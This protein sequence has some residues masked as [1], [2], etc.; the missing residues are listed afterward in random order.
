MLYERSAEFAGAPARW[1]PLLANTDSLNREA[2][3]PEVTYEFQ[4]R[5][6]GTV[7]TQ[8][9]AKKLGMTVRWREHPFEWIEPQGWSVQRDFAN[10]PFREFR[11]GARIEPA[12]AGVR[13][14]VFCDLTPRG[15]FGRLTAGAFAAKELTGLLEICRA[16]EGYLAGRS[17]SPYP[18]R[19]GTALVDEAALA[20]ALA[21][22]KR[23]PVPA[24]ICDRLARH[25]REAPEEF[26][27]RMR[28]FELA[29]AWRLDRRD[30]LRTMLYATRAGLLELAYAL[31]CTACRGAK[32]GIGTM[33]EIGREGHCQTC[34]VGFK[35]DFDRS[36]E[37]RFNVHPGVRR[38][39]P[40]LYCVGGP[41]N[42]PHI[43]MQQR[44]APGE[45]RTLD[46][47][48][49]AGPY[50]ARIVQRAEAH[51]LA[52][53]EGGPQ[54]AVWTRR[55]DAFD[56]VLPVLG[57]GRVRV[58]LVNAAAEEALFRL[59]RQDWSDNGVS[60]AQISTLPEFRDLFS[61]E[62]LAPGM[63]L[64]IRNLTFFF[65]D[66]KGSTALYEE[67]GDASAYALVRE[68]FAFMRQRIE[69]NRGAVVKTMGDA[70]MA[71]FSSPAD[72][73]R[74]ACEIQADVAAERTAGNGAARFLVKIGGNQG[75]CI[76]VTTA[77]VLDYFGTTVNVAARAEGQSMGNDIVVPAALAERRDVA[78]VLAEFGATTE[79][80]AA[81]L[82]GITGV[83]EMMRLRV[84][85]R[86][87]CAGSAPAAGLKPGTTNPG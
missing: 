59:E 2:G 73:L 44:L 58:T 63:D 21:V 84:P 87:P 28:P 10:G 31:I 13:I 22:L 64:A 26:V 8:A 19:T 42:T 29:D 35:A 60:A 9:Q 33:G 81:T 18:R 49:P 85:A 11:G 86:S 72:A 40:R 36:V 48:L 30:V 46:F 3:L 34:N 76:A 61:S 15:V 1:W 32:D 65:T 70:V 56:P 66:L 74:S 79:R 12:G 62:A 52:A 5:A 4:P 41:R 23:A 69:R 82:K 51:V 7:E 20:E 37:V 47:L 57:A 17:E 68:H 27:V 25:L 78:A 16:W 43:L 75:P 38:E 54:E 24:A 83:A 14:T 80:V 50:H 55:G 71:V 45:R 67:V 53:P 6:D 77:G 39:K